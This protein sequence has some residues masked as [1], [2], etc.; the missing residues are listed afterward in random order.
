MNDCIL[1]QIAPHTNPETHESPK[2]E[3][4]ADLS[5]SNPPVLVRKKVN[6]TYGRHC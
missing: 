3:V 4:A 1:P 6:R 2:V 5:D